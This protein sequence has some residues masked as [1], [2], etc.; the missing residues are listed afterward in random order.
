MRL[1][2]V[3][4]KVDKSD[5][6]LG[7]FH[8]WI[9]EFAKHCEQVTVIGQFVGEY[10][11]PANVHVYSLGK[12]R[13]KSRL[14]QVFRF[15]TLQWKLGDTYDCVFVHMTPIWVVLGWDKWITMRKPIYLWYEARGTRWPLRLALFFVRKVFSASAA[16]MPLKT[17][18][19]VITGHGID[20]NV[21]QLIQKERLPKLFVTVG[22]I[23]RSKRLEVIFNV[24]RSVPDDYVLMVCGAPVTEDDRMYVRGI[25][26]LLI[27]E[28][29]RSRVVI[30][31]CT[32][33]GIR[34]LLQSAL[35]FLH[36]STTALDKAVLEAMAC[37]C[38]VISTNPA[39]HAVLPPELCASDADFAE[40]VQWV[41]DSSD[42]ERRQI[43][44]KLRS[45]IVQHHDLK[46]LITR[47][48][49]EMSDSSCSL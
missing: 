11:L 3:T 10:A 18:K 15:W 14:L 7:F 37:G 2:I 24:L 48:V 38:P 36:T 30:R 25:D 13:G 40:K 33:E 1:L 6:V 32:Q 12:E 19:S 17:H 26:E 4:Q 46:E 22:R 43:G 23:T 20:T 9:G 49:H 31:P 8:Q 39:V 5:P 42:E 44:E 41:L 35:A 34:S 29:L 21:F 28:N 47:L 27:R 16:G 45:T